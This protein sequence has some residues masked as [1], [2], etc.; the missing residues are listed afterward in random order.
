[1]AYPESP[2]LG[3]SRKGQQLVDVY[4]A[5]A[6]LIPANP[7]LCVTVSVNVIR[8]E[9]AALTSENIRREDNSA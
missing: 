8:Q 9:R 1:M 3:I 6:R 7:K 2:S 5:P 4:T